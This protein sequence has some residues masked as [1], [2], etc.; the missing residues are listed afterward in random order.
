MDPR[1]PSADFLVL[2]LDRFR[3]DRVAM[4]ALALFLLISLLSVAAPLA[5]EHF[6]HVDPNRQDLRHDYEPPSPQHWGGTDGLGRDVLARLLYAGRVSLGIGFAVAGIELAVGLVLG[7]LA[8][9][10]HGRVDDVINAF[11]L[12]RAG[13]PTLYLLILLSALFRDFVGTPWGLA[14]IFG[15][16]GWTGVTRQVRGLV[17]S[18]KQS[19]F[20][21]AARVIGASDTRI[22]FRHILPHIAYVLLLAVSFDIAGTMLG[23]AGLSYLGLGIQPPTASWGN[24]LSGGLDDFSRAP[25]LAFFPGLLMSVTIL[26]IFLVTD[27]LR[28]ALDPRSRQ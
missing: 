23:E 6:L 17:L 7:L 27:G 21:D 22:I 28:D 24:M 25:W 2:S 26:S 12:L 13:I 11:G 14:I 3:R 18:I 9:Y 5:M 16:L 20:V 10:Y 1:E 15:L 19:D 8:G 4:P